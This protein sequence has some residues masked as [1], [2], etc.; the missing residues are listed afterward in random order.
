MRK[1]FLLT[2]LVLNFIIFPSQVLAT[3]KNSSSQFSLQDAIENID[4]D[5]LEEYKN[6]IDGEINSCM[7]RKTVKDWLVDFAK[8]EWNFDFKEIGESIMRFF[9]K[10]II[11]NSSLLGKLLILS[12]VAALLINLQNSFSSS[13]AQMS[14]LVCFLALCAI[15]LGSFRI[16][17]EIGQQTIENMVAFMMGMLPQMLVITAGLGGV[18]TS[19]LLFPVLMTA[20]AAFANAIKNIVFPL[21][22][23]SAILN[24]VNQ[25]SETL[26]VERLAKFFGQMAQLSL[27]FFFTIFVGVVTLRALYASVL[28]KIALRTAKF[29]SDN[30]IPIIGKMFSETLEVAAGYLMM[31][32]QALGILGLLIIF[33][34]IVFPLL[35]IAA[36][37]IIYKAAAAIAEPLGDSRTAVFLETMGSH[38]LLMLAAVASVALMFFI[39]IAVVIGM[40]SHP[41]MFG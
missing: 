25:M 1:I 39:M 37:S 24:L 12:V 31:I 14:Y 27:G 9:F 36:I 4:L 29:V 41:G 7:G 11:A 32:K 34:L 26:K 19:V 28:D 16:V 40:S 21:I 3:D 38:L 15:A 20:A 35:K 30:A 18:N 23:M 13:V 2:L 22:I 33:G 17:L 6:K 10:E 5:V 8:G